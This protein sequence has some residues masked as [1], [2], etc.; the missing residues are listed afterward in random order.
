M[1]PMSFLVHNLKCYG[2]YT[3]SSPP[4]SQAEW[5]VDISQCTID[6][7]V[8]VLVVV[9]YLRSVKDCESTAFFTTSHLLQIKQTHLILKV[10]L[11]E[12]FQDH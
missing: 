2:N 12:S 3:G 11:N 9:H 4:S 5:S 10:L 1:H 6:V 7:L 8:L